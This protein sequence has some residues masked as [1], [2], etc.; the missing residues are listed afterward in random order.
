MESDK[1]HTRYLLFSSK[2]KL[3]IHIELFVRRIVKM[4]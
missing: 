1:E 3:L 4:L 2:E